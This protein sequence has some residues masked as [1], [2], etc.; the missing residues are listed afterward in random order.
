MVHE[1]GEPG[2][3]RSHNLRSKSPALCLLSY[4]S[5]WLPVGG[6]LNTFIAIVLLP[7]K[8]LIHHRITA[9]ITI[10][11]VDL[12]KDAVGFSVADNESVV[13]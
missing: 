1:T 3:Q 7:V 4:G 11:V 8:A 9:V 13:A 6:N 12:L 2:G 5:M 10:G